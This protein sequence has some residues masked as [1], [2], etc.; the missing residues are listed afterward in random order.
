MKKIVAPILLLIAASCNTST[1]DLTKA[2][3]YIFERKMRTDGRLLVSYT[4]NYG[5]K[6]IKDSAVVSNVV[7]PQDSVSIVFEKNNPA[8]SNLLLQPGN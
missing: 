6:L 8:N 5:R 3:A 7:L 4:F 2:N 1:N